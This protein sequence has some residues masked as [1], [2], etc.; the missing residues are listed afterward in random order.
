M[1]LAQ[2]TLV[3]WPAVCS[4]KYQT[5]TKAA[6]DTPIGILNKP[7]VVGFLVATFTSAVVSWLTPDGNLIVTLVPGVILGLT[8]WLVW[9]Y[10]VNRSKV[11]SLSSSK[12]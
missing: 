6:F 1:S 8:A 7:T 5:M 4:P 12:G 11:A 2:A 10:W 9:R 3:R